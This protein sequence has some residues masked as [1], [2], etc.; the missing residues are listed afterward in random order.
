[1][2]NHVKRANITL[3]VTHANFGGMMLFSGIFAIFGLKI[4]S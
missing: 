4:Y 3:M 1:M 2:Q